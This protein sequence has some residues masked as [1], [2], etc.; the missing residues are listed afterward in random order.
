[1]AIHDDALGA[2]PA[3]IL[4]HGQRKGIY[5]IANCKLM[6]GNKIQY[7]TQCLLLNI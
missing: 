7:K 1:M 2:L 6:L 3:Q 5:L 4:W